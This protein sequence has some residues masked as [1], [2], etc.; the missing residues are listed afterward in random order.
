MKKY[1]F[2]L[3]V[4]LILIGCVPYIQATV[5]HDEVNSAV[6]VAQAGDINVYRF[7]DNVLGMK[8]ICYFTI[9]TSRYQPSPIF[10]P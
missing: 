2:I 4:V 7:V 5:T 3:A 6:L 10:C 9:N 8:K 1:L